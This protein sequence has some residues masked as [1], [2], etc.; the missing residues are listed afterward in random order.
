MRKIEYLSPSSIKTWW[1]DPKKFYLQYLTD[2]R[3]PRT[4][5]TRPMAAGSALDAYA[6]S[7][8][9]QHLFGTGTDPR[10]QFDTLFEAQVESQNRDWA[11]VA[12]EYLFKVY[13]KSGAM[14]D[15]MLDLQQAIGTP[16]F[17]FEVKG[18]VK[19]YRE[20]VTRDVSGIILLGKPDIF[21]INKHACHV[22][23]DFKVNGFCGNYS[24][25]P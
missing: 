12:G 1:E 21:Y 6:K 2:Q 15:L 5:Q 17:E 4:E 16:K 22:V 24:T 23:L 13:E 18:I 25:N 3:P 7:F 20:G 19:G 9:H 11:K 8:L 14:V 10:F